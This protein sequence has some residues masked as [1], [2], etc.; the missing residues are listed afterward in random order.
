MPEGFP[1]RA[2]EGTYTDEDV[3]YATAKAAFDV[4][5]DRTT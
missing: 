3:E 5:A 2:I 4:R 1:K